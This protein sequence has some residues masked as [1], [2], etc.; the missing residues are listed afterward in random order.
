MAL[1]TRGAVAWGTLVR[2]LLFALLLAGAITW[3]KSRQG[4]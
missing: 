2:W 3:W 4:G 1:S